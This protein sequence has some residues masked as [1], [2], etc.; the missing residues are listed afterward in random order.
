[1]IPSVTT[2]SPVSIR[3]IANLAMIHNPWL[4]KV[5]LES[6]KLAQKVDFIVKSSIYPLKMRFCLKNNLILVPIVFP[7]LFKY[8][9]GFTIAN[10]TIANK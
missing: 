3:V 10:I 5:P 6:G 9:I 1:M 4:K 8:L 7:L 2:P